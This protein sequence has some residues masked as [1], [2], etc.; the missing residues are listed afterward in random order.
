MLIPKGSEA[1][2]NFVERYWFSKTLS[3]VRATGWISSSLM[4]VYSCTLVYGC[5]CLVEKLFNCP[6]KTRSQ[7]RVETCNKFDRE[8]TRNSL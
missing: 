2:S 1:A 6:P 5:A 4:I 8:H 3:M 7:S